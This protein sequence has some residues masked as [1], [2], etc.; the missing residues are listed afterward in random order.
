M[1]AQGDRE[2]LSERV[3]L[4]SKNAIS[5]AQRIID[6]LRESERPAKFE[7]EEQDEEAPSDARGKAD[8]D[9]G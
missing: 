5:A 4:V 2:H 1:N 6:G 8:S 9:D 3:R 7:G